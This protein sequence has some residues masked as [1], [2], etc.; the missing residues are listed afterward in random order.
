MRTSTVSLILTITAG[1]GAGA[2][3]AA[4]GK[5]V[6]GK[7]AIVIPDDCHC[8]KDT[9]G[10]GLGLGAWLD[11]HWGLEADALFIQLQSRAGGIQAHETEVQGAIL[12]DPFNPG[13]HWKPYLRAGAGASQVQTPFSLGPGSTTR[14]TYHWG[15]GAQTWWGAHGIGSLELR[16]TD[17]ETVRYRR[18]AQAI[19]GLGYRWGGAG[20]QAPPAAPVPPAPA[21]AAV[22]AREV[23]DPQPAQAPVPLPVPAPAPVAAA[24]EPTPAA[25][26]AAR[27]VLDEVTLHFG[28]DRSELP[29]SA[30]ASIRAVAQGLLAYPGPYRLAVTGHTSSDGGVR[31]N[32]ALSL[33]RARAVAGILA[34]AG[35]PVQR[36]DVAGLGP[37]QPIADNRSPA[38]KAL[39]RRVEIAVQAEGAEVRRL[40]D[41]GE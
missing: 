9:Y 28:N 7:V 26:P 37:A 20:A 4:P 22:P 17:V 35:I 31:H 2:Q 30:L 10:L 13:P 11:P 33:Q 19:L 38:G 16:S 14:F 15:A 36:V 3:D 8:L 40:P 6:Q 34:A 32:Q 24:P 25:A 21:T 18:E 23:P 39:N 27:A 5:W 12:F 1:L 29:A 41:A